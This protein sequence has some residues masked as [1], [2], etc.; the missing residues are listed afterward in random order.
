MRFTKLYA[1]TSVL[2]ACLLLPWAWAETE[3]LA[4]EP[5]PPAASAEAVQPLQPGSK[6]PEL[7]LRDAAGETHPLKEILGGKPAVVIF[8]RGGWCPFCTVHL[9]ALSAVEAE[10]TK[11]GYHLFALAPD[12][13]EKIAET[14]EDKEL[15][16]TIL[17]DADLRAA[18]SFGVAFQVDAETVTT[19]KGYGIELPVTG[20]AAVPALP[21]P[22]V[23][24]LDGEGIV[25]Y[26]YA[27]KDYKVRLDND[28]LLRVAREHA[29]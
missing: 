8:Y 28:E 26:T 23:F 1:A 20:G 5:A 27:N 18:R 10:L 14:I 11:L 13:P 29:E 24:I 22:A 19:Y 25:R 7:N 21:V 4:E 6:V 15:S 9:A 3:A 2:A 17:S 16:Y 12:P